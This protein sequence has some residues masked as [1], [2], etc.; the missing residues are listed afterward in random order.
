MT[1]NKSKVKLNKM[2]VMGLSQLTA[3]LL[4][5]FAKEFLKFEQFI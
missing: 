5:S 4:L 1:L 3:L 2:K